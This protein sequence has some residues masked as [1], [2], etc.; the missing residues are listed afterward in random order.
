ME[1]ED[2][3]ERNNEHGEYEE[4]KKATPITNRDIQN[5]LRVNINHQQKANRIRVNTPAI[6]KTNVNSLSQQNLIRQEFGGTRTR[7]TA[8][9]A[10]KPYNNLRE[11]DLAQQKSAQ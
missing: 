5:P 7:G 2:L 1:P 11:I 4:V 6:G 10:T 8:V 3:L 9:M